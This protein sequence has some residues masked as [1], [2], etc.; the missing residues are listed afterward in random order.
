MPGGNNRQCFAPD[1]Q[2]LVAK[3]S[4][5]LSVT[6]GIL[7]SLTAPKLGALSDRYGRKRLLIICS[8]GG[9]ASETVTILAAR[10]PQTIDYRWMI[11]GSVFDGLTGSFTAGSVLSHA[12]ASDCTPPSQRG[13]AIGYL[14]SC[15]FAGI[16]FGPLLAGYFVEWTGSLVSIFY[17]VLGCHLFFMLF[18][19]FVTP[20]SLS[21]KQQW[22]AR[23]KYAQELQDAAIAAEAYVLESTSSPLNSRGDPLSF[24]LSGITILAIKASNPFRPLRIL[25]DPTDAKGTPQADTRRARMLRRNLL[26]LALTDMVILGSAMSAGGIMVLYVEATFGWDNLESSRFMS[27]TSLVRVTALMGVL[28]AVNWVFRTRPLRKRKEELAR[29]AAEGGEEE[30][31]ERNAGAD[32]LDLWILRCALLSEV[33]GVA[34]YIFARSAPVFV[35]SAVVASLGGLG[36]ATIQAALSKHVPPE[37]VGQLLGAIGL[38]HSLARVFGPMVF[39]QLYAATVETAPRAFFILLWSVFAGALGAS[40]LVTPHGMFDLCLFHYVICFES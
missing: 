17:V 38:L 4:L 34:G 7:S 30:P 2:K 29:A 6:S 40:F 37:R 13:V 15:L 18:I 35:A 21:K 8:L 10:H 5:V 31:K 20:E 32:T 12:Y 1:V 25:F 16:A 36:S 28:P 3:F 26:T 24:L 39:N 27:M 22:L 11:L 14:H 9:I 19:G 33:I 23:V